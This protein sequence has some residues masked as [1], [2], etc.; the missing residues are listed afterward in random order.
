MDPRT[1]ANG[2]EAFN[3]DTVKCCFQME[4]LKKVTSITTCMLDK[5]QLAS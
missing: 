5:C 3:T 2:Q 1:S 4:L